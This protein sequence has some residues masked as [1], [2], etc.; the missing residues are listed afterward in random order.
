MAE[1]PH[2]NINRAIVIRTGLR[3]GG[4]K[5][6]LGRWSKLLEPRE[7]RCAKPA[8]REESSI[9]MYLSDEQRSWLGCSGARRPSNFDRPPKDHRQYFKGSAPRQA[10]SQR[11]PRENPH[12]SYPPSFAGRDPVAWDP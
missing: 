8:R 6:H 10:R 3:L 2:V 9:L 1:L 5:R 7:R 12:C 4:A 11:P